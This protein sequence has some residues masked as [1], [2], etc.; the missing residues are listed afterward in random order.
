MSMR[1]QTTPIN[2]L[3]IAAALFLTAC[4]SESTATQSSTSASPTAQGL[5]VSSDML[6]EVEAGFAAGIPGTPTTNPA[7]CPPITGKNEN[8]TV[9]TPC[10]VDPTGEYPYPSVR[11]TASGF[12]PGEAVNTLLTDSKGEVIEKLEDISKA[13]P[14]GNVLYTRPMGV[15]DYELSGEYAVTVEGRESGHKATAYY[16]FKA[17]TKP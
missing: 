15:Y 2:A 1:T 17:F 12:K 7:D 9:H 13:N 10:V 3:V 14:N 5:S 4:G 11:I 8:A 6:A 16:S